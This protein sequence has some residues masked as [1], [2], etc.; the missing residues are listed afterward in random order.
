VQSPLDDL[1]SLLNRFSRIRIPGGS[2]GIVE[3]NARMNF[4]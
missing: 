3:T 1:S 2:Y 4:R